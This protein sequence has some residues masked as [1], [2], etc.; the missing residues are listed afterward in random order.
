MSQK[1]SF[2]IIV[3]PNGNLVSKAFKKEDAQKALEEFSKVRAQGKEAHFYHFPK[4]DKRCKSEASN[5][6][7]ERFTNGGAKEE[8]VEVKES[9]PL[10]K[11]SK[12]SDNAL[13]IE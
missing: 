12:A 5:K 4:A 11:F 8:A 9:K 1:F 6:E 2:L 7:L 3:E 13:D 10:K